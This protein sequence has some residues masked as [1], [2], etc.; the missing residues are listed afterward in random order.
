MPEKPLGGD[1]LS[2][3]ELIALARAEAEQNK[4]RLSVEPSLVEPK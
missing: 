2:E 3:R 1:W 4:W